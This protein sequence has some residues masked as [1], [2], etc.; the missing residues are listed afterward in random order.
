MNFSTMKPR[1]V[2]AERVVH[3]LGFWDFAV[4]N[5]VIPM[6]LLMPNHERA[7]RKAGSSLSRSFQ[8]RLLAV[9]GGRAAD[10]HNPCS[11]RA[12]EGLGFAVRNAYLPLG[13]PTILWP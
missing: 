7:W 12:P 2:R 8:A 10:L 9:T 3:S 13:T 1:P 4:P 6:N 11:L 5:M